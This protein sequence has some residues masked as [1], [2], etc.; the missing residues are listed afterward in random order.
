[1]KITLKCDKRY[2]TVFISIHHNNARARVPLGVTGQIA[3]WNG[4]GFTGMSPM[5]N[6]RV[7]TLA[8][9]C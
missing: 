3:R 9:L 1:M 6:Y 2:G 8:T 4:S 7:T 5:V